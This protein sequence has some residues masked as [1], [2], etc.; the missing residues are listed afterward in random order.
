MSKTRDVKVVILGDAGEKYNLDISS[1]K[2]RCVA[3][4]DLFL[5]FLGVGKTSILNRFSNKKFDE[6]S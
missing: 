2:D 3:E 4:S 1:C 5:L 6:N